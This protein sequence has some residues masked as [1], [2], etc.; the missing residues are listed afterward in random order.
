MCP[1][2]RDTQRTIALKVVRELGRYVVADPEICHGKPT[3]RGTRIL[4][5][6]ILD[7]IGRGMSWDEIAREWDG[8]VGRDAIAEIVEL[9]SEAFLSREAARAGG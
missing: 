1:C 5:R 6:V 9:A 3:I 7:Q 8:K 4:V 2:G